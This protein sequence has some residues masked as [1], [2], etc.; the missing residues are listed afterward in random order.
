MPKFDVFMLRQCVQVYIAQKI[1]NPIFI[2][3]TGSII[4]KAGKQLMCRH[5]NFRT[6]VVHIY[7]LA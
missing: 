3:L 1:L 4:N 7:R 6:K 5:K 2:Y